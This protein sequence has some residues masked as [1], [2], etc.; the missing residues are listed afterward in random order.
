[1][2][3]FPE[4]TMPRS[5]KPGA[6]MTKNI[7]QDA[8]FKPKDKDGNPM[9]PL[10]VRDPKPK[11]GLLEFLDMRH[12]FG[13]N[14][15]AKESYVQMCVDH[16]AN[17]DSFDR[18]PWYELFVVCERGNVNLYRPECMF[19]GYTMSDALASIPVDLIF[20][21]DIDRKL[22]Y[23]EMH[24]KQQVYRFRASQAQESAQW[25]RDIMQGASPGMERL[26]DFDDDYDDEEP[27]IWKLLNQ[28][29]G[30]NGGLTSAIAK[31]ADKLEA[32]EDTLLLE[33]FCS[34]GG[35]D[36][37]RK[38][39]DFMD[40]SDLVSWAANRLNLVKDKAKLDELLAT[41]TAESCEEAVKNGMV[42][43]TDS[44]G[45]MT[46]DVFKRGMCDPNSEMR[47]IILSML[48]TFVKMERWEYLEAIS[49]ELTKAEF[50]LM[51]HMHMSDVVKACRNQLHED[52]QDDDVIT[53]NK[54]V[55]QVWLAGVEGEV[56]N[57]LK[58]YEDYQKKLRGFIPS[59]R[60]RIHSGAIDQV[61][62]DQ[63]LPGKRWDSFTPR[64][65]WA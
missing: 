45:R 59:L 21:T 57:L 7:A 50:I 54:K 46:F 36:A 23:I 44:E 8:Y 12:S 14:M 47:S 65:S 6:N 30:N 53:N 29:S 64:K 34:I 28:R 37:E 24:T 48:D 62:D 35:F 13:D 19:T 52:R 42:H 39:K 17:P 25:Q 10:M 32:A 38:D 27:S 41:V 4:T 33:L 3:A 31:P 49:G 20:E 26:D 51:Y 15:S 60:E 43:D 16:A 22:G 11:R 1:M 40:G 55:A 2:G 9:P 5:K 58:K 56:G 18:L 61:F 63:I